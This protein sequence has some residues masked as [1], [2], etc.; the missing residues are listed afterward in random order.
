MVDAQEGGRGAGD[1]DAGLVEEGVGWVEGAVVGE[2]GGGE[3]EEEDG[4]E[5]EVNGVF[6]YVD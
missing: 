2:G 6:G 5:A 3:G 4:V 1:E